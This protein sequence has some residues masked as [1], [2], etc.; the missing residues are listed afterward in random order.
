MGMYSVG[1]LKNID[2]KKFACWVL[3]I[4]ALS[5][6]KPSPNDA[7][8]QPSEPAKPWTFIFKEKKKYL[9]HV[10]D[11]TKVQAVFTLHNNTGHI[12]LI[13]TVRTYCGCTKV[14]YP[15]YAIR[16]GKTDSVCVEINVPKERT[17]FSNSAVVYFHGQKPV[18]LEVIGK[19]KRDNQL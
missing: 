15:H 11:R 19:R 12:Q 17:F 9:L 13:D 3:C 7:E 6:C 4:M 18:V 10:D 8:S 5:G 2:M 16:D 14:S 1:G